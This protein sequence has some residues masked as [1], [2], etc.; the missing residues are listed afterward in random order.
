M[1]KPKQGSSRY[2]ENRKQFWLDYCPVM[3]GKSWGPKKFKFKWIHI[4]AHKSNAG[5]YQ[6]S[7]LIFVIFFTQARFFEPKFY[8]EKCVNYKKSDFAIK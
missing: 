4:L 6:Q 8:T 1:M 7:Y 2:L 5:A 3:P